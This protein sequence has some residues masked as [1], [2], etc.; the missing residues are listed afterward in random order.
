MPYIDACYYIT[1][2]GRYCERPIRVGNRIH[3]IACHSVF[4]PAFVAFVQAVG[5]AENV[6]QV[7][8]TV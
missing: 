4:N 3:Y 6:V 8:G 1:G 2:C 5:H 7:G